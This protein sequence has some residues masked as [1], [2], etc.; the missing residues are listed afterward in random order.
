M[1]SVFSITKSARHH[2]IIRQINDLTED[3]LREVYRQIRKKRRTWKVQ[4]REESLKA[5]QAKEALFQELY[6]KLCYWCNGHQYFKEEGK[7]SSYDY[8]LIDKETVKARRK[9]SEQMKGE[10]ANRAIILGLID[11]I[12]GLSRE[13]K[14]Q[15]EIITK[16]AWGYAKMQRENKGINGDLLKQLQEVLEGRGD[17]VEILKTE[18]LLKSIYLRA[19]ELVT[20]YINRV[21]TRFSLIIVK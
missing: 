8:I 17:I 14:C 21:L 15:I 3:E 6:G 2:P 9:T 10:T 1:Q 13:R 5:E 18:V 11:S 7:P 4:G 16:I 20:A 19:K 12:Q